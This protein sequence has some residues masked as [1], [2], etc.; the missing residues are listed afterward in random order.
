MSSPNN[1][2]ESSSRP[3]AAV[4]FDCFFPVNTGGGERLYRRL[5]EILAER[6]YA[7]D[8][9]TRDQDGLATHVVGFTVL[10]IWRGSIYDT[11]GNRTLRGALSFSGAILKTLRKSKGQ[12]EF[13][14][15]SATPVLNL[16]AARAALMGSRTHIVADWLE[17]WPLRKWREYSG[18]LV[19]GVAFALQSIGLGLG[20]TLTAA[21]SFTAAKISTYRRTARPV[22]L[23]LIDLIPDASVSGLNQTSEP[24]APFALFVGRHIADKQLETLPD[25]VE[26]ARRTIPGLTLKIVGTGPETSTVRD[27]AVTRGQQDFVSFEGRVPDEELMS[28]MA[29]AS[30]LVNPSRREGFGLV[31]AEAA[32]CGT[33]S[34]VVASKDNAAVELIDEGINGFVAASTEAS[35]LGLTIQ[36]AILGGIALR[37]STRRWFESARTTKG[38]SASV[39]V[40][41]ER[42]NS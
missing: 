23:G 17:V 19:G 26:Y 31:I 41:L 6:G 10:P 24:E 28:L 20:H 3:R 36:E 13:V 32:A 16:F 12:Y 15:V 29:R 14:V 4:I 35:D 21:S 8:Y 1:L 11:G 27:A 40:L 34:V 9:I 37:T 38:M 42:L 22:V 5:A 2:S 33:P 18:T 30:V 39:D 7:V 25:A